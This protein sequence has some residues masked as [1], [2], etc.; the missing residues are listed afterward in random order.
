LIIENRIILKMIR[1]V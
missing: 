1:I